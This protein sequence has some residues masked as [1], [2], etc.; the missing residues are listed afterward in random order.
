MFV[1]C[2]VPAL[3]L[4]ALAALGALGVNP[5]ALLLHTTG[6]TTL[7]LLTVTLAITPLRY[8]MTNL[9]KLT[10]GHYGKRLSDWNWLIKLRRQLGLWCF[11]YAVAHVWVYIA[12]D[13]DYD[14]PGAWIDIQEKPFMAAGAVSFLLLIPLAATATQSMMRYLGRNWRRLHRLT[15]GVAVAGLLHFWW[16]MKPG[17]HTP[18]PDT[19]VLVI[20]LG[21]RILLYAG[22]LTPWDGFDGQE[23]VERPGPTQGKQA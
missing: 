6:R 8:W 15:Y 4:G 21:Y 19:L 1:A 16:M 20:L 11:F 17:L 23:S 7:V 3:Y 18:W 9:S 5:L 2:A 13:L 22:L 12:F 10:H 14:W